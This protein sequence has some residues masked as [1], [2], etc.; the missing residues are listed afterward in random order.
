MHT[1]K[2]GSFVVMY[3]IQVNY[4]RCIDLGMSLMSTTLMNHHFMYF[5]NR[6]DKHEVSIHFKKKQGED[7]KWFNLHKKWISIIVFNHFT[8]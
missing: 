1:S 4:I 5:N 7:E 8:V 2:Y 6:I 3:T